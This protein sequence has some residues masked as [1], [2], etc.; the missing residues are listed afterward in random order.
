MTSKVHK[1]SAKYIPI[2][3]LEE[4]PASS[5]GEAAQLKRLE[6]ELKGKEYQ[7]SSN[8]SN[9]TTA[10]NGS[11]QSNEPVESKINNEFFEDTMKFKNIGFV[12]QQWT[13]IVVEDDEEC[14]S[15]TTDEVKKA[16]IQLAEREKHNPLH[17]W[18]ERYIRVKHRT[19]VP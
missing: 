11:K 15:I 9:E 5:W 1:K 6:S 2:K 3:P 8:T 12:N 14:G 18:T 13:E 16:I 4:S 19:Y 7:Q 17:N 10:K